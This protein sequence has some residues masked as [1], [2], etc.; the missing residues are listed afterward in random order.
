MKKRIIFSVLLILLPMFFVVKSEALTNEEYIYIVDKDIHGT[1][2]VIKLNDLS[3]ALQ[4]I[5]DT[6]N[7]NY[8]YLI[9]LAKDMDKLTYDA[10]NIDCPPR[11]KRSHKY[12]LQAMDNIHE[13]AQMFI[14]ALLENNTTKLNN[15]FDLIVEASHN[16]DKSNKLFTKE[17]EKSI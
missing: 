1:E 12:Y 8:D 11:F 9:K 17:L 5:S 7:I 16:M 15:A 10:Y 4:V 14:S 13:F 2:M 6:N 3:N